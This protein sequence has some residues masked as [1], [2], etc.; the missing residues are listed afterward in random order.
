MHIYYDHS[1]AINRIL[2]YKLEKARM[3]E[4]GINKVY[5]FCMY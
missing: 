2:S 1:S 5:F 4:E 3:S